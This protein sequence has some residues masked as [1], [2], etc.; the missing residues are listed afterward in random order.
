VSQ[1]FLPQVFHESS[2]PKPLKIRVISNFFQKFAEIFVSLGALLI[3]TTLWQICHRCQRYR[4][5]FA[6]RVID[7]GGKYW[8]EYQTADTLSELEENNNPLIRCP[9]LWIRI[10]EAN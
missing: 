4:G 8:E 9:E 10:Q 6:T 7:T 5:K 1:D 3:S 2:S